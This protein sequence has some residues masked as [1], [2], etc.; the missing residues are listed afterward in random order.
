V[1]R[2]RSRSIRVTYWLI[3]A[4]SAAVT[5]VTMWILL[6]APNEILLPLGV[7]APELS[8][9]LFA[10]SLV[11]IA[12]SG[13][14]GRSLDT[15]RLA[16]VL[17][18]VSAVL[19]LRPLL[20]VPST[21]REFDR[22]MNTALHAEVHGP[23][24]NL[25][26]LFRPPR[27][28]ASHV[29]RG[30]P[31]STPGTARLALDIYKPSTGNGPFP[32]LV[33]IY[34]G[35]WQ[36]GAPADN[37]WFAR[38][39]AARGYIVV[40]VDYRHAPAAQWPAQVEDVR[41]ALQW[42]VGHAKAFDGDLNRIVV[43]G[44]S[45]GAQ[46]ALTAVYREPLPAIRGVISCYGPTDLAEGWRHPPHPD[47][48][49]VRML[50]GAYLG[51]TPAQVPERYRDAS[52]VTYASRKLPPTLLIY[53]RRDHIVEARF[54]LQ[55]DRALKHAG[56]TSVLLEI[57]WSEHAFDIIPNGLAGQIALHYTEQFI[58]WAVR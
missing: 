53:G 55:L 23:A 29:V 22:A 1:P 48:L 28:L 47:P 46:L 50:L 20:Q 18:L 15:A 35:A 19:S 38:Y 17:S 21:L 44:R 6:P 31:F 32:I 2:V 45:S 56:N 16:L 14:Y 37:E 5:F 24:L 9:L 57:P 25:L 41:S 58:R 7:A 54:G 49:R 43:L 11:M 12:V 27:A 10:I 26:N 33:Q 30:V 39:F 4:V 36:R 42:T 40:A 3:L 8:P 52:P 34:G 13:F 51:G